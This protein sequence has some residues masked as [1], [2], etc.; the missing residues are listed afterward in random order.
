MLNRMI[1]LGSTIQERRAPSRD[2]QMAGGVAFDHSLDYHSS[3]GLAGHTFDLKNTIKQSKRR[4][5][6][7]ARGRGQ[8]LAPLKINY[9]ITP[10]HLFSSKSSLTHSC[11]G[12]IKSGHRKLRALSQFEFRYRQTEEPSR[13]WAAGAGHLF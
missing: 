13:W 11:I 12:R 5:V 9:E 10:N 8:K 4:P 2:R 7:G 3:H 6:R 1:T